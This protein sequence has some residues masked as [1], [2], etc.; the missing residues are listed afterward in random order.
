MKKE[1]L[2]TKEHLQKI[3]LQNNVNPQ[4]RIRA[5]NDVEAI[6][7]WLDEYFEKPTTFRTYK[8]EAERF[9]VWLVYEKNSNLKIFTRE[10]VD[11]YIEFVKNPATKN[12]CAQNSNEN[13]T[14]WYPFRKPLSFSA[15]KS[16]LS[17]LNSMMSYLVEARYADFNPFSLV[18][19]K[20]Q[21]KNSM[22]EQALK[23]Q[24]RILQPDEWQCFMQTVLEEPEDSIEEKFRKARLLFLISALFYL[25]LRVEEMAQASWQSFKKINQKWWFFVK[26]KGDRLGK[27]PINSHF[28]AEVIKYRHSQSLAP[29]PKE[30]ES[31]PIIKLSSRQMANL[32]KDIAVKTSQKFA[33][34]PLIA[35]KLAKISPHWLRHLSASKQDLAGISF[36]NIRQ[37]LRHQNEQTTRQ[38]VHSFDD[39]RHKDMEKLKIF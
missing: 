21:F 39:D 30:D 23:V 2:V 4:C 1:L 31:E 29:L 18:R 22:S 26:G 15:I 33:D 28:L 34:R 27:I 8:K 37:N 36:T 16:S 38:Y 12:W 20:S 32:I 7:R 17:I 35:Q 11:A 9:L 25:G 24:E 5:N 10:D 14:G 6:H 3:A 13:K 19:K